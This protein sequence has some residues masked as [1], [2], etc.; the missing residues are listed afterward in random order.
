MRVGYWVA[1][2]AV[3]AVVWFC[4]RASDVNT[5][6]PHNQDQTV[7]SGAEPVATPASRDALPVTAPSFS[8]ASGPAPTDSKASVI[9]ALAKTNSAADAFRAYQL[10]HKC[11]VARKDQLIAAERAA[12][13]DA[14]PPENIAISCG[15]ISP[16]Q[17]AGRLQLL[18][19]A[20]N[21]GVHGA[22]AALAD[23][24]VVGYGYSTDA[25]VDDPD[26]VFTQEKLARTIEAGAASGD[27]W[28]L[29]RKADMLEMP[30]SGSPDYVAALDYLEKSNAAYM[31]ETGKELKSYE[32]EKSR[33]KYRIKQIQQEASTAGR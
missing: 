20:A 31:A 2:G 30:S 6:V 29:G 17:V 9:D 25:R 10:V 24:G 16:G 27:W 8:L 23:E 1:I 21:A 28:S 32:R 26:Y 14:R 12:N 13:G 19:R 5:A 18:E 22:A 7:A 4:N 11:V 15:D 3:I 33:L